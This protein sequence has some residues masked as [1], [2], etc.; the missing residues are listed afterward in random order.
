MPD[1]M[2]MFVFQTSRWQFLTYLVELVDELSQSISEISGEEAEEAHDIRRK[3][4]NLARAANTAKNHIRGPDI[5]G[6]INRA[7]ITGMLDLSPVSKEDSLLSKHM[8][9]S[10]D[11]ID[12]GKRIEGI[13]KEAEIGRV[14][15]IHRGPLGQSA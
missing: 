7:S 13:P 6:D 15:H 3:H 11:P 5:F 10:I 8:E 2:A 4:D 1:V 9:V 12:R 14:G